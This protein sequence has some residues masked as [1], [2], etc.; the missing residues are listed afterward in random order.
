MIS[1]FLQ[2][3]G[4]EVEDPEEEE[5][6]SQNL[7]FIDSQAN[8]IEVTIHGRDFTIRQSP[9]VLSSTRAGGTT[10]AVLWKISPLISEWLSSKE[11]PLWSHSILTPHA[12]VIEL[13]CG[14]SGLVALSLSP[15]VGQYIATDQEYVHKLL[16]ENL[17]S[18]DS[19]TATRAAAVSENPRHTR[20]SRKQP[21]SQHASPSP[22]RSPQHPSKG[23]GER[24][25]TIGNVTFTALDWESSDPPSVLNDVL[26]SNA[27]TT[28]VATAAGHRHQPKSSTRRNNTDDA[29]EARG[30]DLVLACDCIYNEALISPLVQ[31]CADI[32]RMRKNSDGDGGGNGGGGGYS[33]RESPSPTRT[34]RPTVCVIAQQL[35]S[36]DVFEMWLREALREFRVWRVKDECVGKA[37]GAG[38]GYVV[39]L[40]VLKGDVRDEEN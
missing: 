21:S 40:L 12:H 22:S 39:H 4:L 7:G 28:A 2:A 1:D 16:R 29:Q 17:E 11:N 26:R 34:T 24:T 8:E 23:S 27:A 14:I 3:I 30:F 5:I 19:S 35:R 36:S 33:G 6:P 13:G 32:C 20:R 10:G 25:N 31:T 38:S 15:L 9:T 18:N 37:L